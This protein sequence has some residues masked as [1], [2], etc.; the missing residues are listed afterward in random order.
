MFYH[1]LINVA[2]V[3]CAA[4]RILRYL[5]VPPPGWHTPI[6]PR[7]STSQANAPIE[8]GALGR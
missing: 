4:F 5:D 2:F 7:L 3:T 1:N 8:R 6:V